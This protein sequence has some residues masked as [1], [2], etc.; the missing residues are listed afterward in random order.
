MSDDFVE[1]IDC[2]A[3]PGSPTLCRECLARRD[4][5]AAERAPR[6]I[7]HRKLLACGLA[8]AISTVLVSVGI[9]TGAEWVT[10]ALGS[11]GLY[12]GGNAATR[13]AGRGR[14]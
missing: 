1:C 7:G 5:P 8:L 9:L 14:S 12:V 3:K 6:L 11:T 10:A 2:A 13:F 4:G